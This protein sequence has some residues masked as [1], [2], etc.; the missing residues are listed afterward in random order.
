MLLTIRLYHKT[1]TLETTIAENEIVGDF[2]E[3]NDIYSEIPLEYKARFHEG[4]RID[5]NE[6]ISK[7]LNSEKLCFWFQLRWFER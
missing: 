2:I 3:K 4:K 1:F 6:P 7:Y 5:H